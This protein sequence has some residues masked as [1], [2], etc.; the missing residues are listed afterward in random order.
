MRIISGNYKGKKLI[1]PK[2]NFTRP[3]RDSVKESI[4]NVLEHS[5][6]IKNKIKHSY[7]LDLFSG[8]GS[9]GLECI[10]RESKH[11]TFI[12]NHP[13]ALKMLRKNIQNLNC[14]IKTE[15]IG[16]DVFI[17]ESQNIKFR[18]FDF[19]FLDPPFKESRMNILLNIIKTKKILKKNGIISLH[20]D[21]KFYDQFPDNFKILITKNYGRSKIFFG[22]F[23]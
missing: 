4:F 9:F 2:D 6:F 3:L 23:D 10:S 13:P 11:V 1:I 5:K 15:I 22:K 7:I 8:V 16:K 17:M 14:E 20:R 18:D 19:I 12:E 21:K